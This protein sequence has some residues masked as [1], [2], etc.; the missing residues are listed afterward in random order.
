MGNQN[1]VADGANPHS[2]GI[3]LINNS[4]KDLIISSNACKC[5]EQHRGFYA[6]HGKFR[7]GFE[8]RSVPKR[9]GVI[10]CWMSGREG[11]AV[12]PAGWINFNYN[13]EGGGKMCIIYTSAGLSDGKD[14]A[15]V[16]ASIIEDA[17]IIVDVIITNIEH[18]MGI[19]SGFK[20]A[21]AHRQFRITV[22]DRG[23]K[24]CYGT[25][26]SQAGENDDEA[27]YEKLVKLLPIAA[28]FIR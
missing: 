10:Q 2:M 27:L 12:N 7:P 16:K 14:Q 17:S 22:S 3:I 4:S 11:S 9:G 5:P 15:F 13:F 8:P 28:A 6:A 26:I 1:C 19:Y 18:E 21:D 20:G 23:G 25:Q 24:N